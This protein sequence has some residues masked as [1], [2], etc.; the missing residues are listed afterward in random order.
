[1]AFPLASALH[2]TKTPPQHRLTAFLQATTLPKTKTLSR[3]RLT[4]SHRPPL[5][6]RPRPRRDIAT[7]RSRR[8]MLCPRPRRQLALQSF[9]RP[10]LYFRPHRR[11]SFQ[12][13]ESRRGH[14]RSSR[15]GLQATRRLPI[16][17]LGRLGSDHSSY[18]VRPD[19]FSEP[20]PL[21]RCSWNPPYSCGLRVWPSVLGYRRF[22]INVSPA[23]ATYSWVQAGRPATCYH[24]TPRYTQHLAAFNRNLIYHPPIGPPSSSRTTDPR[25]SSP[26]PPALLAPPRLPEPIVESIDDPQ[27][28]SCVEHYNYTDW[29]RKQR[30]ELLCSATLRFPSLGSPSPPPDNLLDHIPSTRRPPFAEVLSLVTKGQL[31][32]TRHNTVLLVHRPH[33]DSTSHARDL[34]PH[35]L[36][37]PPASTFQC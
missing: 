36:T 6:P 23:P 14:W 16:V 8:P 31:H 2:K 28:R 26:P 12:L 11:F 18:L 1:M 3:Y 33:K 29:A 22:K 24:T 7:P 20:E 27:L 4:G 10:H 15:I 5:C 30:A 17:H 32:T 19:I 37:H 21:R 9:C 34:H 35:P 25:P 13:R